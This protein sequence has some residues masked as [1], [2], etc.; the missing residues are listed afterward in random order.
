MKTQTLFT[1][2]LLLSS[3]LSLTPEASAANKVWVNLSA[4]GNWNTASNWSPSGVP[5]SSDT[6]TFSN[7]S[8]SNCALNATVSVY[9]LQV[10]ETYSGSITQGG[11][12]FTVGLGGISIS[13]GTFNGSSSS[14]TCNGTFTITSGTFNAAA[15]TLDLNGSFT[16]S[17]GTFT[18]SSGN[19]QLATHISISGGTF[20]HNNGTLVLDGSGNRNLDVAQSLTI[21]YLQ[22]SASNNDSVLLASSDTI[23]CLKKVRFINGKWSSSVLAINDTLSIETNWDG[24]SGT[25]LFYGSGNQQIVCSGSMGNVSMYIQKNSSTDEVQIVKGSSNPSFGY[26]TSTL[27]VNKGTLSFPNNDTTTFTFQTI[28]IDAN[29]RLSLPGSRISIGSNIVNNGGR[30]IHNSGTVLFNP[31]ANRSYSSA[32]T[33]TFYHFNINMS[34]SYTLSISSGD[35]LIVAGT[36]T[37]QN[38]NLGTGT[39]LCIGSV[40]MQAGWD[41]GDAPVVFSGSGNNTFAIN[42]NLT[43]ANIIVNKSNATDTVFFTSSSTTQF[44]SSTTTFDITKGVAYFNSGNA[45]DIN[46]GSINIG[47][48][49]TFIASSGNCSFSGNLLCNGSFVANGGTFTFDASALQTINNSSKIA[50]YNLTM[51]K[52]SANTL[53]ISNTDTLQVNGALTL[54]NG[55]LDSG[56]VEAHG[57]V[58]VGNGFDGGNTKLVFGGSSDQNFNL[59]SATGLFNGDIILNKTI[60]SA[61]VSLQ[62]DL[63]IDNTAGNQQLTLTRGI[64]YTGSNTLMIADNITVNGGSDNSFVQGFL[65]KTGN[66]AFTFPMGYGSFYAPIGI[67]MPGNA[68]HHFTASYYKLSPDSAYD[69]ESKDPSLVFVGNTEFW[70]LDRTNGTSNVTVTLSWNSSR[71]GNITDTSHLRVCRWNGST[72]KDHGKASFTGTLSSGTFSTS[73]D[74]T[75]FSPFT[76][77]SSNAGSLPVELLYFMAERQAQSAEL[78]WSTATEKNNRHFEIQ[79][80]ENGRNFEPIGKV[81]SLAVGGNSVQVL[82][83]SFNDLQPLPGLSYYRLRQIDFDGAEHYSNI[84][85][86]NEQNNIV[87]KLYPNPAT[88]QVYL[89][90]QNDTYTDIRI[91]NALGQSFHCP[92]SR[93]GLKIIVDVSDLPK[94]VYF[95][96]VE[97]DNSSELQRFVLNP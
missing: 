21:N 9:R 64:L 27:T 7:S 47:S 72:W 78:K 6:A 59:S 73:S 69:V 39:L 84:V 1:I 19:T 13:G 76:L 40:D 29:G 35:S 34:S 23:Y 4:D 93:Q 46:S 45:A 17:G 79:R 53:R 41:A 95:M 61:K 63:N 74:V 44:G 36:L 89:E 37:L 86:L 80:S 16:Q 55:I 91:F 52:G 25:A 85:T 51:N 82:N 65:R 77:G 62:S 48:S 87:K 68:T 26:T 43:T 20:N 83:Y 15:G 28:N 18:C 31:T 60:A 5:G 56:F 71:S 54:T 90:L 3:L 97:S 88:K 8:N 12:S 30:I 2:L 81:S 38:G 32:V 22:I 42:N 94:G 67:S 66:D 92:V 96:Q 50:F 24:G 58:T 11:S 70:I 14:I 75:S 10:L 33:D 57:H 49:G